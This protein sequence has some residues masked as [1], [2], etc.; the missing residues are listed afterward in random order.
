M[1]MH[2][3][4]L[5]RMVVVEFNRVVQTGA[6]VCTGGRKGAAM[7]AES[8]SLKIWFSHT[9][10]GRP[11]VLVHGWGADSRT[12]W[13]ETGWTQALEAIRAL[14]LIDVRGHGRS[15]KPQVPVLYSYAAMSR[16]VLAVLDALEID[17]CDFM[18]YSMGAFMGAWLLG[19]HPERFTSMVLGGI[20]NESE[21]SAAQGAVIAGR[22]RGAGRARRPGPARARRGGQDPGG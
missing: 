3:V 5:K 9:G 8:D 16:D 11:L 14:I 22:T 4:P 6:P 10:V 2:E 13:I 21:A 7:F 20:G 18:G 12:N 17:T 19:H 15:S 1:T